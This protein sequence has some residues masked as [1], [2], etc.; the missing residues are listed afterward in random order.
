MTPLVKWIGGKRQLLPVLK[1]N[2][3][4]RYGTYYEPFVGGGA[5][6]FSEHPESFV[7]NDSNEDLV[8]LYVSVKDSSQ[9]FLELLDKYQSEYNSSLDK[10]A[11]YYKVRDEE[12]DDQL[13]K[14]ARLVFLNKTCFNGLYRVNSKGKF[15]TP[16]NK[17]EKV[18]LYDATNLSD[19]SQYF[20][21][22]CRGIFCGSWEKL[23]DLPQK[24][25]FVYLDPPYDPIKDS[26]SKC[27]DYT[28]D[29]FTKDDQTKLSEWFKDLTDRGVYVMESNHNTE[30]IRDLYKDFNIQ[31]MKARRNVNCKGSLRGPVEE[32]LIKN[33]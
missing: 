26:G 15:N 33:Y 11:F 9:S 24:G 27:T 29:G 16:W 13:E 18:S 8:S 14:A 31:V 2:L 5:L 12:P 32:V 1:A 20:K 3:P 7:V 19:I 23:W 6:L 25:D 21:D 30:L 10:K 17:V 22:H 28:S 4:E